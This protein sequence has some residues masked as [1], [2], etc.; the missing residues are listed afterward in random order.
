ME[1]PVKYLLESSDERLRDFM[2]ARLAKSANLR[3]DIKKLLDDCIEQRAEAL[4]AQWLLEH[5]AEIAA[6]EAPPLREEPQKIL[7]QPAREKPRRLNAFVYQHWRSEQ[8]HA[9]RTR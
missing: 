6:L 9:R 3:K 4:L 2:L 8:R 7:E 1:P 5:G